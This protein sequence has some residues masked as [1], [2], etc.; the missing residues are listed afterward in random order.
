MSFKRGDRVKIRKDGLYYG[1]PSRDNPRGTGVYES[2]GLVNWGGGI[3]NW[4]SDREIELSDD[5]K[6]VHILKRQH[7]I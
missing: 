4:Y 3:K 5:I 7:E 6:P 2:G 1:Y